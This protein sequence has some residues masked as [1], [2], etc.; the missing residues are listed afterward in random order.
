MSGLNTPLGSA[1]LFTCRRRYSSNCSNCLFSQQLENSLNDFGEKWVLNP[2]DGAFY[3]PKVS[4]AR[5]AGDTAVTCRWQKETLTVSSLF[6]DWH[7]DQG[8]HWSI[9]PVRNHSAWFPASYSLRPYLCQVPGTF[10]CISTWTKTP[11]FVVKGLRGV[12]VSQ[13]P[14][15]LF[16]SWRFFT[17]TFLAINSTS[18]Y[19]SSN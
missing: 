6:S 13:E 4:P 10:C 1:P 17:F 16:W 5:P 19:F 2:G 12:R 9:P 8:R 3:G 11:V 14:N 18:S 7:S 15:L